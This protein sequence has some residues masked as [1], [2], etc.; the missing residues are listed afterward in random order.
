MIVLSC[1]DGMSCGQLALQRAGIKVDRYYALEIDKYAIQITQKN[2]P[3][4]IQLGDI[5]DFAEYPFIPTPDLIIGGSPCQGFSFAGKQLNFDDPRSKLFFEYVKLIEI[6]K[7][8]NPNLLFLLENVKMKKEWQDIISGMLGV[9][10]ILINSALVSAQK[11]KRLYWT[12][13]Q[14]VTQPEDKGIYLRDIL[15]S[16]DFTHVVKNHGELI[17]KGDKSMCLDH[18]YWKGA[19]NHGQRSL[20]LSPTQI[21]RGIKSH[22][23]KTFST[24]NSRGSMKF[25]NDENGKAKTLLTDQI[26]GN[27]TVNHVKTGQIYRRLTPIECERLQTVPDNYTAGV[28]DTQ[29]YRML[30]NG[31]TVDVPADIFKNIKK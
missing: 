8:E 19:D 16:I 28:S 7:K 9:Q 24:G 1:F 21:D 23:G 29:R 11:R 6:F 18:N 20:I 3:D 4:T 17:E 31:W 5:V 30:G 13:I 25:P 12:N 2:F 27:R 10:P 22:A 26:P 14:G 15:E